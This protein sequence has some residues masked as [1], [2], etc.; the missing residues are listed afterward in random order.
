MTTEQKVRQVIL[1]TT[2][3]ICNET[4]ENLALKFDPDALDLIA[5][6]VYRQMGIYA[7]DLEAFQKHAKRTQVTTDDV[8]LLV[9]RNASLKK[10]I[11]AKA[12]F[13]MENKPVEVSNANKRKRKATTSTS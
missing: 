6:M 4:A 2:K 11:N 5:E 10:H 12:Q 3:T 13:I 9:R 1:N 7:E 8:K